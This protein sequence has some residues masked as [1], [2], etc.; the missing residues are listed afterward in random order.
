MTSPEIFYRTVLSW[1][2]KHGRKDLPWQKNVT[3]YRVWVSEI[4]LQ[5]T[6]VNT[7]I[8]YFERFTQIFPTVISL[9]QAPEDK[10]LHLWTG[11]GYYARARNL[12]K[13]SKIITENYHGKFPVVL[14]ELQML[15][16]IGRSTAGAI[17][18]LSMKKRAAILDGNVKRV[19]SRVH[20]LKAFKEEKRLWALAEKYTPE[21]NTAAYTQ[22]MMDLGAMV[23]TRAQPKCPVCPLADFCQAN[24]LHQQADFPGKKPKKSMP[25]KKI[26]LLLLQNLQGKILLEKR[27]DK[28]IWGGL[29]S[30]PEFHNIENLK[31][32]I[33]Q[34]FGITAS[35]IAPLP[36]FRHT[37]THFHLD[38]MP[39][40]ATAEGINLFGEYWYDPRNPGLIGLAAPV[41]KLLLRLDDGA[42]TRFNKPS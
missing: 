6:Q 19:L 37:F 24:I 4:M 21:K 26:I 36:A 10:V 28:G 16:G 34:K 13:T 15:P 42:S 25:V 20:A 38:I 22:A 14:E 30:L 5:Q 27:A 3:P 7:V 8:A 18:S 31:K 17:L 41:K 12:H 39:V 35:K 29:W 23:C 1:Y 33:Q 40:A 11:L 2:K 32:D 9:A